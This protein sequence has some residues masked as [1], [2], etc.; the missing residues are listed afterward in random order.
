[1]KP[2]SYHTTEPKGSL[3]YCIQ[4]IVE[5]KACK[6]NPLRNIDIDLWNK[7]TTWQPVLG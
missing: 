6:H 4:A 1:M 2:N 3:G 7:R 5:L